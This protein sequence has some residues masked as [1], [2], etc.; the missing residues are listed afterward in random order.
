M[1]FLVVLAVLVSPAI[2]ADAPKPASV[3]PAKQVAVTLTVQDWQAVLNSV[4]D[5]ASVSARDAARIDQA[6]V[7]Q[8]R[9]QLPAN[10]QPG[11]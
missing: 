5:S 9:G 2:A 3:D 8:I 6:I 11:K 7:A 4:S 1:R 10:S